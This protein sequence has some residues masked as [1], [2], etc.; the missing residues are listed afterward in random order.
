MQTL[1]IVLMACLAMLLGILDSATPE[2]TLTSQD[3]ALLEAAGRNDVRGIQQL[4]K[5]GA[6]I[7]AQDTR[8]R[9]ALL[10]AVDR[11]HV[12]SVRLLIEAGS[13]VNAQ[14]HQ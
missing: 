5:H 11:N 2:A 13:D 1:G 10:V 4:V 8:G 6:S 7:H 9:T 12:E 3:Q 14:D